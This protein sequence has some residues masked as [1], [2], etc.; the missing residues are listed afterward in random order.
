MLSKLTYRTQRPFL[1]AFQRRFHRHLLSII[2]E[3]N[4]TA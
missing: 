1:T 3:D 4:A 2:A